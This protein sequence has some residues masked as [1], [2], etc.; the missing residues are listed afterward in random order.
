MQTHQDLWFSVNNELEHIYFRVNEDN[1]NVDPF[2]DFIP[3]PIKVSS[4]IFSDGSEQTTAGGGATLIAGPG[5]SLIPGTGTITITNTEPGIPQTPWLSDIDADGFELNNIPRIDSGGYSLNITGPGITMNGGPAGISLFTNG[6]T[7]LY[8][9]GPVQVFPDLIVYGFI[10]SGTSS[11][12]ARLDVLGTSANYTGVASDAIAIIGGSQGPADYGAL[13]IGINSSWPYIPWIAAT[14]GATTQ[15]IIYVNPLGG[16]VSIGPILNTDT[17]QFPLYVSN[18]NIA[19]SVA[20]FSS[21][22][23]TVESRI[24]LGRFSAI[25]GGINAITLGTSGFG[26]TWNPLMLIYDSG[27]AN[28]LGALSFLNSDIS[29]DQ[30]VGQIT[31]LIGDTIGSGILQLAVQR[32]LGDGVENYLTLRYHNWYTGNFDYSLTDPTGTLELSMR[33]F[34]KFQFGSAYDGGSNPLWIQSQNGPGF[35]TTDLL[36]QPAGGKVIIGS[37]SNTAARFNHALTVQAPFY[38]PIEDLV[39]ATLVLAAPANRYLKFGYSGNDYAWIQS[40]IYT[41]AAPPAPAWAPAPLA[42][43]TLGGNVILPALPTSPAGLP[44]G[45][46][47]NN[48]GVLNIV[49]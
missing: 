17:I 8:G 25:G 3:W 18:A 15:S 48:G 6:A 27:G 2:L 12:Q 30:R 29:G 10:G 11:P 31:A 37:L 19:N 28:G 16:S 40:I 7:A 36:L 35:P 20:V 13:R 26:F 5:I 38:D 1:P 33:G 44:A 43:N 42:I 47:W 45:A 46:L 49:P 39:D 9:P 22:S 4:V 32:V 34:N 41:G 21:G 23:D 14:G 24:W